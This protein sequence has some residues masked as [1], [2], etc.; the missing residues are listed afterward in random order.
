MDLT[1]YKYFGPAYIS[2]FEEEPTKYIFQDTV[3]LQNLKRFIVEQNEFLKSITQDEKY[4]FESYT[5]YGD[6]IINN[7]LRNTANVKNIRTTINL[8]TRDKESIYLNNLLKNYKQDS[9]SIVQFAQEYVKQFISI[10]KKVPR[11]S[12][13]FKVFRGTKIP[14]D[15][16]TGFIST[17][18]YPHDYNSLLQYADKDCCVYE[19]KLNKGVRALLLKDVSRWYENEILIDPLSNI[20][21][22]PNYTVKTIEGFSTTYE[23]DFSVELNTYSGEVNSN[24]SEV[25]TI[26]GVNRN[27]GMVSQLLQ[28]TPYITPSIAAGKRTKRSKRKA[29]KTRRR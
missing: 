8:F 19:L 21:L 6:K 17:T 14:S 23:S 18:F 22:Q 11:V 25:Y 26:P 24:L 5:K 28:K 7:V 15:K 20:V 3:S 13:P 10:W 27:V 1:V 4:I 2:R 16:M 29:R 9:D 12:E